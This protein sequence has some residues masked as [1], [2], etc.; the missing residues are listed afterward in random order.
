MDKRNNQVSLKSN[1]GSQTGIPKV[2]FDVV[3]DMKRCSKC[4]ELKSKS[5]FIKQKHGKGGLTAHCKDCA[6]LYHLENRDVLLDNMKTYRELH[7]DERMEYNKEHN[8]LYQR[9]KITEGR[10]KSSKIFG[11]GYFYGQGICLI[12]GNIHPLIFENHHVVPWDDEFVISLCANC[13]RKYRTNRV[14]KHMIAILN[15]IENSNFLWDSGGQPKILLMWTADLP[16]KEAIEILKSYDLPGYEP[17][18][19]EV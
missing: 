16:L 9:R 17:V 6:R 13:H 10:R 12:C 8:F 18:G 4:G 3:S 19:L 5:E 1:F 7:K 11:V 14:D 2:V 15:A